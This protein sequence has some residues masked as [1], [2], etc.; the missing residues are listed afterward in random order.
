MTG[1]ILQKSNEETH[2]QNEQKKE[3]KKERNIRQNRHEKKKRWEKECDGVMWAKGQ[4]QRSHSHSHLAEAFI[5][6]DVHMWD[7]QGCIHILHYTLMAHC[8]SGVIG[9]SVPCSRTLRQGIELATFCL[10]NDFRSEEHTSE[11][12]SHLN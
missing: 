3:R 4:G 11:L 9:G 10:L 8:T 1:V 7:L 12:Q 2:R 6:S 5:Q